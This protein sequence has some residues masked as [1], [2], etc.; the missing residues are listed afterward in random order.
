MCHVQ[1]MH[2]A[3]ICCTV[4]EAHMCNLLCTEGALQRDSYVQPWKRKEKEK[5]TLFGVGLMR[6]Q[7]LYWA[8][9][10]CR[11]TS[12][13]E[14]LMRASPQMMSGPVKR[15]CQLRLLQPR[16]QDMQT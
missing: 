2:V 16:L 4:A 13:N 1:T 14:L 7:M 3:P 11:N 6:S 8:A 9:L 12:T 5:T 10:V 15:G